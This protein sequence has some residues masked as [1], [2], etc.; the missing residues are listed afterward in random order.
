MSVN[1][2]LEI[3]AQLFL[4]VARNS[5][6][7]DALGVLQEGHKVLAHHLEEQS[8]LRTML[9]IL[10]T[11]LSGARH[12]NTLRKTRAKANLLSYRVVF[13]ARSPGS[14]WRKVAKGHRLRLQPSHAQISQELRHVGLRSGASTPRPASVDVIPAQISGKQ[15]PA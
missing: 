7:V 10:T 13:A 5:V 14:P 3:L 6:F 2:A 11:C 12:G 9:G 1:A 15:V 8:L 4:D